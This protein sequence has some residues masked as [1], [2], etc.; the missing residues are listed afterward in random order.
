VERLDRKARAEIEAEQARFLSASRAPALDGEMIRAICDPALARLRELKGVELNQVWELDEELFA[1]LTVLQERLHDAQTLHGWRARSMERMQRQPPPA[2]VE[3]EDAL[4]D[5]LERA[6]WLATPMSERDHGIW[7][8]NEAIRPTVD[9]EE[10]LGIARLNEIR[11]HCGLS[12]LAID[13][14]LCAA[15]RDHSK[16]MREQGFFSH[17]SPIPGKETPW[18][19]AALAGTSA[20]AENI[21]AGATSGADAIQGWWY[22]PGH[23]KNMLG[24]AARVGLGRFDS[25]WTQLLGG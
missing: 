19:R 22:S 17:D 25:H 8:A 21:L 20:S 7:L 9:A 12:A 18:A 1:E 16:D 13:V 15:S 23:H 5:A 24:G 2:P 4:F 14:K 6:A 10:Y 3:T 11:I